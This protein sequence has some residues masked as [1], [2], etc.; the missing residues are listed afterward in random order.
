MTFKFNFEVKH[1]IERDA[2]FHKAVDLFVNS[3]DFYYAKLKLAQIWAE[4][5]ATEY[6]VCT[7]SKLGFVKYLN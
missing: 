7:K 2:D 4:V 6:H 3:R 1:I 5:L